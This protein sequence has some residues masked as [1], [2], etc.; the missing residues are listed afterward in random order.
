MF[1]DFLQAPNIHAYVLN[2]GL[3]ITTYILIVFAEKESM[4]TADSIINQSKCLPAG[5]NRQ[6]YND[7]D[8]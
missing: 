6:L 3:L 8:F 5:Y 7:F 4:D 1:R 2:S